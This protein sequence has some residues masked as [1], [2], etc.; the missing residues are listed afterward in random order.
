MKYILLLLISTQ[1]MANEYNVTILGDGFTYDEQEFFVSEANKLIDH[2]NSVEP[3]AS[4]AITF[5]VVGLIS[6]ESGVTND[7]KG[8]VKNTVLGAHYYRTDNPRSMSVNVDRVLK[9]S[10]TKI[11]VVLVNSYVH[12]GSTK[13]LSNHDR[14]IITTPLVGDIFLHELGGHG[15]GGLPNENN[16]DS[17]MGCGVGFTLDQQE[18]IIAEI[19]NVTYPCDLSVEQ[20]GG[21]VGIMILLIISIFGVG[22][23]YG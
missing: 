5:D 13:Y 20:S 1:I 21:S 4:Y 11:T 7:P 19:N 16:C 2:F 15:I 23:K 12:G 18:I 22:R 14:F 10:D 6:H 3:F 8:V 17:V 9:K